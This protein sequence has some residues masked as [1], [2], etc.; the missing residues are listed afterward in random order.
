MEG[1]RLRGGDMHSHWL[2]VGAEDDTLS[3]LRLGSLRGTKAGRPQIARA[4]PFDRVA[5]YLVWLFATRTPAAAPLSDLATTAQLQ[6]VF[7]KR[8]AEARIP[9]RYTPHCPRAG[10]ATTRFAQ[11]QSFVSLREDGRWRSDTSLRIYLDVV[12]NQDSLLLAG[13]SEQVQYLRA[14]AR[15]IEEWLYF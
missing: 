5:Q 7:T 6:A 11:G 8:L 1:L 12:S 4:R 14:L 3:Y 2:A 9:Q 15:S 13:I 10:W